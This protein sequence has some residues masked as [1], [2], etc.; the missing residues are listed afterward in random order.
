MRA[1]DALDLAF[2]DGAQQLRL[3]LVAQVADLVEEQRAPGGQLE[4]CRA[5]GGWRR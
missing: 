2:L 4:L 1:A 3:Q 5:A